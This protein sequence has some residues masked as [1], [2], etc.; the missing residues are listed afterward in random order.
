MKMKGGLETDMAKVW[1][2]FS[3]LTSKEMT[4]AVKRA[5]NKAAAQLQSQTKSNLNSLIKSD[6]GHNG[7]YSDR[8]SDGVRRG[9]ANGSYDEEMSV[10]VHIMGSR[11]S[12]SGTFRLRMLEKGTKERY[13]QKYNGKALKKP[14]YLGYLKPMWFFKTAN[15]TIETQLD[16]I[17]I[18]EIDKA[19]QKLNDSK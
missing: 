16:R 9:K 3:E 18:E 6:T 12:D 10:I 11:A 4:T 13:A 19:I 14:R 2:E 7:K 5:L 8:L 17:Y 1:E 15:Q